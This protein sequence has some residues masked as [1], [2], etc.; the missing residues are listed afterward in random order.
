MNWTSGAY[1][2][3]RSSYRGCVG[4]GDMYGNKT[5]STAGPWGWG[6]WHS[7]RPD[8]DS[9]GSLAKA[10]VRLNQVVTALPI[11]C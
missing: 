5:D 11:P 4:S 9:A 1:G 7:F 6:L 3:Y 10:G 8:A 2:Y